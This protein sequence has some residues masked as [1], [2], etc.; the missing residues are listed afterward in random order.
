MGDSQPAASSGS[1]N[2]QV[3]TLLQK[4]Q[5]SVD[6]I[7]ERVSKL[8]DGKSLQPTQSV[9]DDSFSFREQSS[10]GKSWADIMDAAD[11]EEEQDSKGVSL[12]NISEKT[13]SQLREN[14]GSVLPNN[15]RRQLKDKFGAPNSPLTACPGLDKVMKSQVS[16]ETK[17]RDKRLARL[18]SL[19]LDAV[20]P[21]VKI[22]EGAENESISSIEVLEAVQTSLRLLGNCSAH[23]KRERRTNILAHLNTRISDM[24]EEDDIFA[25]AG[26]NLFGDGFGKK[27]K[28][29]DEEM[30]ALSSVSAKPAK[31]S[32]SQKDSRSPGFHRDASSHRSAR[33]RGSPGRGRF[34]PYNSGSRKAFSKGS[35]AK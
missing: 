3:L 13:K 29:R 34:Q 28:E 2:Q 25:D 33:G 21:L 35:P 16:S 14:F 26:H 19:A 12:F 8:E 32:S 27:A 18:Q 6:N 30:K 24:A 9:G 23:F 4:M 7:S 10:S 20:G 11:A 15:T 31:P 17:S 1:E 22:V 5:T